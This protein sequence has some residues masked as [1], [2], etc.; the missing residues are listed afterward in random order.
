MLAAFGIAA[1][2]AAC[3]KP[4]IPF[5]KGATGD[6]K[7]IGLL[8]PGY[9]KEAKVVLATSVGRNL[10][11][12]GALV[13]AGMESAR[14]DH[15]NALLQAQHF[16][17]QDA[18]A[19][20]VTKDLE[21]L[22]YKV[23]PV[24]VTR[25]SDKDYLASYPHGGDPQIDA[26]LDLVTVAYGY[27]ASGIKDESPYRPSVIMLAKLVS[28]RDAAVLMQDKIVYNPVNT[29]DKTI[30]IAPDPDF[31]FVDFDTLMAA[32]EKAT[33]GLQVATE[34]SALNLSQLLR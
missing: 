8:T 12:L 15:F 13:D 25:S 10:G 24:P 29:P 4:E 7:T 6:V 33:K 18:I 30:T 23:V 34:Q 3:A 9:P 11:L 17:V 2:L 31:A 14:E 19:Q 5:D 32:P 20:N 16:S 22:G 1:S 21:A 27:V 28:A 26:Y